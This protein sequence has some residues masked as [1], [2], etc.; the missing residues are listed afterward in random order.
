MSGQTGQSLATFLLSVPV[1]AIG[2]MA[3]FGIP[4]FADVIANQRDEDPGEDPLDDLRSESSDLF[5][6]YDPAFPP[7]SSGEDDAPSWASTAADTGRAELQEGR[8]PRPTD[9]WGNR[10]SEFA[11]H[12]TSH[13]HVS[14]ESAG[15]SSGA[16]QTATPTMSWL[17]ARRQLNDL[18]V[19]EFHLEAGSVP[20]TFTF[21]AVFTPGDHPEV[22]YRFEAEASEPLVAVEDVVAQI[23]DWLAD[24]FASGGQYRAANSPSQLDHNW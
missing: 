14:F 16:G 22:T 21:V 8:S 13:E 2:L 15:F 19:N 18:G 11:A 5:G 6:E 23:E 20:D 10:G 12:E 3:V 24:R 9:F 7:T 1:A 4:Q 17:E